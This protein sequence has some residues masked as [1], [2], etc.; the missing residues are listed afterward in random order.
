MRFALLML[1]LLVPQAPGVRLEGL[2]LQG[3]T[4]RPVASVQVQ[5]AGLRSSTD[6]Q[7]RFVFNSVPAGRHTLFADK[8]GYM[9]ARPAGRKYTGG[10]EVITRSDSP[11]AI[12]LVRLFP[13]ALITGRVLDANGQPVRNAFV[14]PYRQTYDPSGALALQP[15]QVNRSTYLGLRETMQNLAIAPDNRLDDAYNRSSNI[16]RS[17][18]NDLGEFRIFNLDPGRYAIYID[19]SSNSEVP[20]FYPGVTNTRDAALIEVKAGEEFRLN[21]VTLPARGNAALRVRINNQSGENGALKFVEVRRKGSQEILRWQSGATDPVIPLGTL[22]PGVYEVEANVQTSRGLFFA[23]GH[24]DLVMSGSDV[25]LEVTVGRSPRLTGRVV[26]GQTQ[27]VPGVRISMTSDSVLRNTPFALTTAADGT[28]QLQG[29]PDGVFQ[30]RFLSGIPAGKCITSA[31]QGNRNVLKDGLLVGSD[32]VSV[33]VTLGESQATVKGTAV[34]SKA[35]R[36]PGATIVLVPADPSRSDLFSVIGADQNGEFEI[37]CVQPGTYTIYGWTDL[38][39]SAYRNAD[40]MKKYEGSGR[41]L[42]LASGR[43]IEIP[44]RVI[45]DTA[46]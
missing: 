17:R 25:E 21:N 30:L 15:L 38:N 43:I 9:R 35:A 37:P 24:Q 42:E 45:D 20:V 1:L 11:S 14:L 8:D 33:D 44:V 18:T 34:D 23:A 6:A 16:T 22:P 32:D 10:I 5:F 27:P 29:I 7:G 12:L 13:A 31:V 40:F 36:I 26:E 46:N 28:F 4:D 3:D 39:G 41:A 19:P 2:V